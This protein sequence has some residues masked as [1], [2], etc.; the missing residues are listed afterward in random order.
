MDNPSAGTSP[1][2][3]STAR[4]ADSRSENGW[5]VTSA[6]MGDGSSVTSVEWRQRG[7]SSTPQYALMMAMAVGSIQNAP[8]HFSRPYRPPF[9]KAAARYRSK[10][11]RLSWVL[12]RCRRTGLFHRTSH[13]ISD[14]CPLA[15]QLSLFGFGAIWQRGHGASSDVQPA[16]TSPECAADHS[17]ISA[18]R[19]VTG[20]WTRRADQSHQRFLGLETSL[21]AQDVGSDIPVQVVFEE[22]INRGVLKHQ[23]LEGIARC[24]ATS[25]TH[26]CTVLY[27]L[28]N[29]AYNKGD[30]KE[31]IINTMNNFIRIQRTDQ[32]DILEMASA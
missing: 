8:V 15:V 9:L 26:C 27:R 11:S 1:D 17:P 21:D 31:I 32:S 19:V 2:A 10:I 16:G 18:S 28:K 7:P 13:A 30:N 29:N 22:R 6:F 25:S 24:S 3:A 23:V 5:L 4:T 12:A 14:T 20:R